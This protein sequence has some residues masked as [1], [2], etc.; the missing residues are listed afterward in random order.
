MKIL[1][2][3]S[4]L[5]QWKEKVLRTT[6]K[7]IMTMGNPT[8]HDRVPSI[9]FVPT[10]GALHDGHLSLV[11]ESQNQCDLT[12]VSIF[13]NPT[14]FNNQE[15]LKKYPSTFESDCHKLESFGVDA[16]F[17]PEASEIYQDNFRFKVTEEQDS[18][19]LCGE[20]REG[21]FTGVL[22]VILKLFNLVS[23]SKAFFGEKDFQQLKLIKDFCSATFSPVEVV[24]V[25]T[26]R[27]SEGLALSSRNQRLS[28]NGL[29][30][31]RQFARIFANDTADLSSIENEIKKIGMEIEYLEEKW[32]RRFA[33]VII[34]G[35]RLIDNRALI[36]D[37]QFSENPNTK[38]SLTTGIVQENL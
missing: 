21:H 37:K 3:N 10:M 9:G 7:P 24:S 35:I 32:G 34:E 26:V 19:G 8:S 15:D 31:A 29:I 25:P 28:K 20:S 38:T 27:D 17:A 4:E 18:L 11:S 1:K 23:P 12:V 33:A 14:Q 30:L 6:A 13:V 2:N 5:S 36:S 22:T 16:V